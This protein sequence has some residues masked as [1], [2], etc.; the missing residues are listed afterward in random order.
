MASLLLN[1]SCSDDS[2]EPEVLFTVNDFSTAIDENPSQ[3]D[4]LGTLDATT[5]EGTLT[6][7][8]A[9]QTPAGAVAVG[10]QSGVLSVA[11][12]SLFV[13]EDNPS[14]SGTLDISNELETK[15]V[16]FS[17]TINE[18][19]AGPTFNIWTGEAL[20]FTKDNGADP[21]QEANQDRITDNVWITR[22]NGGGQI[23]NAA[24][25]SDASKS[26]SPEDTEWALGTTANIENLTFDAF[27]DIVRPQDVVGKDLVLHLISD[28][29]YIDIQ[30][31]SWSQ[32]SNSGGGF[33]YTRST[34]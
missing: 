21:T 27:R 32:G 20:T 30:F 23:Y 33:S 14:I 18:P 1:T 29:I 17:V 11:D 8:I 31:T 3:G 22:G 12:P 24:V 4:V 16:A 19:V 34:Q 26:T 25:E 28:D 5:S 7:S 9:S 13:F 6:F 15:S 10:E 2:E